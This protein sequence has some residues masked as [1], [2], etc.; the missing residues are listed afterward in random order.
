M[1]F[2]ASASFAASGIL[3]AGGAAAIAKIKSKREVSLALIP[4]FFAIQQLTE[5]IQWLS[6]RKSF[7]SILMG[8][9]YL[10]FAFLLWPVFLPFAVLLIEKGKTR[11]KIIYFFLAV[12]CGISAALLTIL[13]KNPL[14]VN[15]EQC[16]RYI[17]D[18]PL[19]NLGIIPYA[20]AT[21]GPGIASSHKTLQIFGITTFIAFLVSGY[22][23]AA[24]FESVWCFF[25]A[26]LSFII[27]LHFIIKPKA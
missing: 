11:R 10:F 27:Y 21:C 19:F 26:V 12:G 1:C 6:S 2:S 22:Y 9:S 3:A 8:Y 17:I 25:S 14:S 15:I 5:G 24:Y 7:L 4:I 13:I 20:A 23:Y 18:I 16:V